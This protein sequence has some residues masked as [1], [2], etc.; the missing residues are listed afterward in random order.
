MG[1]ADAKVDGN[2]AAAHWDGN[3]WL[4]TTLPAKGG[5]IIAAAAS[6]TDDVWVGGNLQP[7]TGPSSQQ[8]MLHYTC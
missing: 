8:V 6:A 5:G 7:L 3:Q 1:S 4:R 2:F